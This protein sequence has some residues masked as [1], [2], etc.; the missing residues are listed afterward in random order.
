MLNDWFIH[1]FH[2]GNKLDKN[3]LIEETEHI[4]MAM[5]FDDAF[6]AIKVY[7]HKEWANQEIIKIAYNNWPS[8]IK[9]KFYDYN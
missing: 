4:L 8:M 5:V 9:E 3:G 6:Y 1:H 2:L 7:T